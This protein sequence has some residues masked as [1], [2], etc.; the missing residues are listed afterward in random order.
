[1]EARFGRSDKGGNRTYQPAQNA[2]PLV[3]GSVA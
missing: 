3:R 1:M 2:P